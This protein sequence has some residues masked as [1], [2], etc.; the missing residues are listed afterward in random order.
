[1]HTGLLFLL[2][3]G[4]IEMFGLIGIALGLDDIAHERTAGLM[5]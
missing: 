5:A 1:V 2:L 3:L 4:R